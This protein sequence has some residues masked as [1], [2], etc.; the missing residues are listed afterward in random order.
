MAEGTQTQQNVQPAQQQ[1]QPANTQPAQPAPQVEH[2]ANVSAE[3]FN[4]LNS[5]VDQL[6]DKLTNNT[7]PAQPAA[8]QQPAQNQQSQQQQPQQPTTVNGL[9]A[10]DVKNLVSENQKFKQQAR[11]TKLQSYA[12]EKGVKLDDKITNAFLQTSKTDDD[13]KAYVDSLAKVEVVQKPNPT[14]GGFKPTNSSG[15]AKTDFQEI[16]NKHFGKDKK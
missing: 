1:Q 11:L 13:L 12:T 6:I 5:K 2:H 14:N 3:D 8:Q 7:Q 15:E 4:K 10:A 16:L 9:T